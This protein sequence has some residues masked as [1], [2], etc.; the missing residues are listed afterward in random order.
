MKLWQTVGSRQISELVRSDCRIKSRQREK[1]EGVQ[2]GEESGIKEEKR[3]IMLKRGKEVSV[4]KRGWR[5]GSRQ[6]IQLPNCC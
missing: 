6:E 3:G 1:I 4:A 2:R 5:G